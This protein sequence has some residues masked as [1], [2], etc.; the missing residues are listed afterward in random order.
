MTS[1]VRVKIEQVVRLKLSGMAVRQ[2]CQQSGIS[3]STYKRL[4]RRPEFQERQEELLAEVAAASGPVIAKSLEAV[5]ERVREERPATLDKLLKLRD[6]EN[7]RVSLEA[8]K[9][10]LDR[11][12]DRAL[13]KTSRT[14]QPG[15]PV[16]PPSPA[17]WRK[18]L[19]DSEKLANSM[20]GK[21]V[22]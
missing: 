9:D 11:D 13:Q 21:K 20:Q 7:A 18:A 22:M 19:E 17:Q 4:L 3:L 15:K 16:Q 1:K 6:S 10:L 8:C 12:P 5:Q 14:F 2:I